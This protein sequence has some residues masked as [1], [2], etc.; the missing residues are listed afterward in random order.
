VAAILGGH[1][2]LLLSDLTVLA[3]KLSGLTAADL[4]ITTFRIDP[5]VL[6]RESVV[7]LGAPGVGLVEPS[8]VMADLAVHAILLPVQHTLVGACDVA[9][10]PRSH[11][12]LFLANLMIFAVKLSSLA[13][14]EFAVRTVPVDRRVLVR[15][16]LVDFCAARVSCVPFCGGEGATCRADKNRCGE[17]KSGELRHAG[18]NHLNAPIG[19]R[20]PWTKCSYLSYA[21][22]AERIP[23][24][25]SMIPYKSAYAVLTLATSQAFRKIPAIVVTSAA[26][27][28]RCRTYAP[29][30]DDCVGRLAIEGTCVFKL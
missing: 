11:V 15:E 25:S 24:R 20:A 29:L 18:D 5:V 8:G 28:R 4:A 9:T 23:A 22:V 16:P 30:T 12:A 1:V 2:T 13:A 21:D 7:H 19:L 17:G 14:A 26:R 27:R 3:V 10:V 6:I